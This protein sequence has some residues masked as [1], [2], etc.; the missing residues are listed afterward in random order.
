MSSYKGIFIDN[1]F[2]IPT[3][4]LIF[5]I[6]FFLSLLNPKFRSQLFEGLPLINIYVYVFLSLAISILVGGRFYYHYLIQLF[7]FLS[8]FIIFAIS[9]ILNS[10]NAAYLFLILLITFNSFSLITQSIYNIQNYQNIKQNYKLQKIS[11]LIDTNEELLALDNHLVYF[12]LD[13]QPI[14]P[15]VHPNTIFKV[16]EYELLISSLVKLGYIDENQNQIIL[17]SYPKYIIC[18]NF[19]Y[20]Y[21]DPIYFE[22][23][24]SYNMPTFCYDNN[25]FPPKIFQIFNNIFKICSFKNKF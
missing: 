2:S 24:K 6:L 15:I 23:Y 19:C 13:K 17:D 11:K 16:D 20:E 18:E 21:I 4:F 12:Y 22:N 9:K 14:T 7:P 5:L 25:N 1:I 10:S 8:I 3:F